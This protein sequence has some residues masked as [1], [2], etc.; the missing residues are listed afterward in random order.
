MLAPELL[1]R[2]YRMGAFPMAVPPAQEIAWFS[3][4]PRALIPLDDRFHVAHGLK[5]TLK[6]D[7]FEVTFDLDFEKVIRACSKVHGSTWISDEILASYCE[8]HRRGYAHSVEVRMEGELAG[9]LYGVHLGG[10]FFGES[11]FHFK[12][13]ASKVALV[14]LV[15]RLRSHGFLFLDTQ[16]MTAHLEQFGTYYV[17]RSE[18]LDLLKKAMALDCQF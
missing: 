18:Y 10:A 9:G 14:K 4:D 7:V 12:T 3:P 17:P 2:A 11:M 5:R 13:D 15:Q 6:K 1:L 8:L 16:W